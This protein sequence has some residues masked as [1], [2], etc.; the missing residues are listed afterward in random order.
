VEREGGRGRGKRRE[1]KREEE[2]GEKKNVGRPLFEK[3]DLP[4]PL[5]QKL[6]TIILSTYVS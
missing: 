6:Y 3:R 5:L 2:E 4:T 1:N